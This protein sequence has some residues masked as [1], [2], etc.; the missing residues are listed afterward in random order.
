M[1]ADKPPPFVTFSS[2]S[3]RTDLFPATA[4]SLWPSLLSFSGRLSKACAERWSEA[5]PGLHPLCRDTDTDGFFCVVD[6]LRLISPGLCL[7]CFSAFFLCITRRCG[8]CVGGVP[9]QTVWRHSG[10]YAWTDLD[11]PSGG[12]AGVAF[13]GLMLQPGLS[14]IIVSGGWRVLRACVCPTLVS[15]SHQPSSRLGS[16]CGCVSASSYS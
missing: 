12:G 9:V 4:S 15:T 1:S 14:R 3:S 7:R 10:E 11:D 5:S 8:W 13:Y 2:T 6:L 16:I